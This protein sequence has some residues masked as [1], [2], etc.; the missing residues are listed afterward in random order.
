M[1]NG[2]NKMILKTPKYC[3][4]FSCIADRCSDNCCIGWEIDIDKDTFALY[5]SVKGDFGK[6]LESS[7]NAD[8]T[9]F[10]ILTENERCPFLN[11]KNLCDIIINLGENSLCQICSDHPRYFEWFDGVKE[12]GIGLCCEEAA[13]IILSQKERL[14]F[15]ESVIPDEE[16]DYYDT[17]LYSLLYMA[18]ERIFDILQNSEKPLGRRICEMLDF[19]EKLQSGID[20]NDLS[21]P[22]SYADEECGESELKGVLELLKGLEPIDDKWQPYLESIISR[23]DEI[24]FEIMPHTERYLENISVYFIFRYFLKGVFDGEILSRVKLSAISTAVLAFMFLCKKMESGRADL[25]TCAVLAKNYSKETEYSEENLN[26][27]LDKTYEL[28]CLSISSLKGIFA[29]G[30]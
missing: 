20:N 23:Y 8:D 4:N 22:E 11:D 1:N 14:K 26:E 15:S 28:E 5:K 29:L 3:K 13:R 27:L 18:R 24:G 16:C 6:R 25:N 2:E 21:L 10:F 30:L 7:I 17:R 9:P 12:G 19:A